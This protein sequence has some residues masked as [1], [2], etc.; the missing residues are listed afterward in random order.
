MRFGHF[1]GDGLQAVLKSPKI[2]A[3]LLRAA[4]VMSYPTVEAP[5]FSPAKSRNVNDGFSRGEP[6]LKPVSYCPFA[7]RLKQA[8]EKVESR[9]LVGLKAS[10]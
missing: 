8:A 6:G 4:E 5:G 10:S 7:A 9:S 3:A 1:E 2:L